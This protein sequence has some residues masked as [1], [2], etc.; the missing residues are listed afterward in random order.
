MTVMNND[1]SRHE[2]V[3][4][5]SKPGGNME[6]NGQGRPH[7]LVVDDDPTAFAVLQAQ[8]ASFGIETDH[9]ASG[10]DAVDKLF[11]KNYRMVLMDVSMREFDGVQATRAIRDVEFCAERT[12]V[13]IVAVTGH[14]Q[15]EACLE[16]GM[17]DFVQKPLMLASLRQ[18][19]QRWIP[20]IS[21]PTSMRT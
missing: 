18:L 15:R 21:L 2:D 8:L 5:L 6:N 3:G 16:A 12:P 11:R 17:D 9:A 10:L 20:D 1:Q 19:I 14:Q 7:V 4:P 13:P